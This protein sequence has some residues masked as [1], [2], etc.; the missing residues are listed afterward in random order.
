MKEPKAED[1]AKADDVAYPPGIQE[2]IVESANGSNEVS[3]EKENI[4]YILLHKKQ[5]QRESLSLI[6]NI[7]QPSSKSDKHLLQSMKFSHNHS[8]S[9]MNHE[10]DSNT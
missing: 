4:Q 10:K 6:V 1:G 7:R 8:I 3:A 2:A 5:N 9:W